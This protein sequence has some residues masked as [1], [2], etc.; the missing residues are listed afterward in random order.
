[1]TYVLSIETTPGV[2]HRHGF[3]LGT[4]LSVAMGIVEDKF[5]AMTEWGQPVVTMALLQG[6]KLVDVYYG[7]GS[8]SSW[9][10]S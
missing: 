10:L 7:G 8:W 2:S 3:H 4:D 6:G 5:A 1:M 9:D